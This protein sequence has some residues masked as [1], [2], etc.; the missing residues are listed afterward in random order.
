MCQGKVFVTSSN[1]ITVER[2]ILPA[3]FIVFFI[4][5]QNS[6]KEINNYHADIAQS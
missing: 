2:N 6:F 1:M 5:M 4:I 3:F